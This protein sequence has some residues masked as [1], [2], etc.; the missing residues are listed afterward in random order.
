MDPS[1]HITAAEATGY[2]FIPTIVLIILS[3][4]IKIIQL[5]LKKRAEK[6]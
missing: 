1:H 5:F 2:G 6:K 4:I 3:A